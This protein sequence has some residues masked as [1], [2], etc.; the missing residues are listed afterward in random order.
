M[1]H[2]HEPAPHSHDRTV[3]EREYPAAGLLVA[4]AVLAALVIIGLAVLWSAPW[5][6]GDANTVPV[7]P[8]VTDDSGGPNAPSQPD[9]GGSEGGGSNDGGSGGGEAPAQ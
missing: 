6:D 2:M 7:D 9:G 1:T 8:P 3:V 4:I 5:D